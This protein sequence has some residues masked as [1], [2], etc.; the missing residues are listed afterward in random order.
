M[1]RKLIDLTGEKYGKLTVIKA[2]D[3]NNKYGRQKWL[4]KCECGNEIVA[5][6]YNI[7]RGHTESCGCYKELSL[8]V[9]GMRSVLR[10]YKNSA[11]ERG[12]IFELTEK[13]F[14]KLIQQDC[15]YCGIKP[16]NMAKCPGHNDNYAYNGLDRIDNTKSYTIDNVVTCCKQCNMA[17]NTLKTDEYEDWISRS[18][19][20][21]FLKVSD[22]L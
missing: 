18:Y 15:Y 11:K 7:I 3:T 10:S 22:N 17:K 19:E 13:Q 20:N 8:D 5:Y 6:G 16:N 21:M 14:I 1:G 12:Y 4:C 9:A 2:N